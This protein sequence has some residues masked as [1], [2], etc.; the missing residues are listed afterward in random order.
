MRLVEH[1]PPLIRLDE[2][3][4][5]I[6][7]VRNLGQQFISDV[8]GMLNTHEDNGGLIDL[9]LRE[10]LGMVPKMLSLLE[11]RKDGGTET[12]TAEETEALV[13]YLCWSY[14]KRERRYKEWNSPTRRTIKR[15]YERIV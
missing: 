6:V 12:A 9:E 3:G 1:R 4:E 7:L 2:K 15:G 11:K 13:T 8:M 14:A 10:L 5:V